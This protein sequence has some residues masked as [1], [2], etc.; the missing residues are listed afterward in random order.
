VREKELIDNHLTIQAQS[1]YECDRL[2]QGMLHYQQ[3][4]QRLNNDLILLDTERRNLVAKCE[5]LKDSNLFSYPA[6]DLKITK[7]YLESRNVSPEIIE[8]IEDLEKHEYRPSHYLNQPK[9]VRDKIHEITAMRLSNRP[10][11]LELLFMKQFE[12]VDR[13]VVEK[14]FPRPTNILGFNNDRTIPPT[15]H[16]SVMSYFLNM[17]FDKFTNEY[18]PHTMSFGMNELLTIMGEVDNDHVVCVDSGLHYEEG[19]SYEEC[20]SS[21]MNYSNF[22]RLWKRMNRDVKRNKILLNREKVTDDRGKLLYYVTVSISCER[23]NYFIY[24]G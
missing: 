5:E 9:E 8:K 1:D 15:W 2:Q 17:D 18:L 16:K 12:R 4:A 7:A 10:K 19:T 14:G 11:Y 20:M 21:I 3:V 6:G 24:Y 22:A 13:K 23:S